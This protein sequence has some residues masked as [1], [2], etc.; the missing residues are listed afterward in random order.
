MKDLM[1]NPI[2]SEVLK[3]INSGRSRSAWIIS[4]N[5]KLGD[6]I[7]FD[8]MPLK[9][10]ANSFSSVHFLSPVSHLLNS[11]LVSCHY[12]DMKNNYWFDKPVKSVFDYL[13]ERLF[14]AL[15]ESIDQGDF[16]FIDTGSLG[17]WFQN[18]FLDAGEF[19]SDIEMQVAR[20]YMRELISDLAIFLDLRGAWYLMWRD[21]SGDV[22]WGKNNFHFALP[23]PSG[24]CDYRV[25]LEDSDSGF[26]DYIGKEVNVYNIAET[27]FK[28][29]FGNS[30]KRE[31]DCAYFNAN[32][33]ISN[34]I[35]LPLGNYLLL[36]LNTG[37]RYKREAMSEIF[38]K[39]LIEF[40]NQNIFQ[41][42]FTLVI[43][44]LDPDWENSILEGFQEF[45]ESSIEGKKILIHPTSNRSEL[46]EMMSNASAIITHCSG[47]SHLAHIFNENVV[48]FSI[49]NTISFINGKNPWAPS[50]SINVSKNNVA[51][52]VE[53]LI[54]ISLKYQ[55]QK[56]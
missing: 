47:F 51:K 17:V 24:V 14:E 8:M 5:T 56:I 46:P 22:T 49:E 10:L 45:L 34:K 23:N 20:K 35:Q 12:L 41:D 3:I 29:I 44:E 26:L 6:S 30:F 25:F 37:S 55:N 43:T 11:T 42:Q 2:Q 1:N 50:H 36:N 54:T 38:E 21:P 15:G 39:F 13:K 4:F 53:A 32:N 40:S 16:L 52:S 48:T 28:F 33:S 9:Y 31:Y 27:L 19:I 18:M 7:I